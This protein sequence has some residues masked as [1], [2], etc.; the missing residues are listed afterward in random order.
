MMKLWQRI[1]L[2]AVL[3]IA[4]GGFFRQ[5][6]YVANVWIAIVASLVLAVL[7]ALVK[8]F[9]SL[10]SLPIT[11]LT[12]GLFSIVIN[13]VMLELTSAVVGSDFQFASF[14]TTLLIAI[15]MSIVNAVVSSYLSPNDSAR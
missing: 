7:N 3:F 9:L 10:L 12:L 13:A 2:N 11:V 1:V 5:S 8:P 15:L 14:G 4:L 6:F